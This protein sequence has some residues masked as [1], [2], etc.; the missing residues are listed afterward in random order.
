MP[1]PAFSNDTNAS[2]MRSMWVLMFGAFAMANAKFSIFPLM[3][4][5]AADLNSSPNEIL[6]AVFAYFWGGLIAAPIMAIVFRHWSKPR[7]LSLLS[8]WCFLGNFLTS[9]AT[10]AESLYWL[11]WFSGIPHAAFLAFATLL[12]TEVAPANKRGQYLGLSLIGISL[13]TIFMIPFNTWIGEDYGWQISFRFVALLDLL[14]FLLMHD[15]LPQHDTA[16][17]PQSLQAQLRVLKN[18]RLWLLFTV[19]LCILISTTA[20]WTYSISWFNQHPHPTLNLKVITLITL[21]LGFI[22]GQVAG[23]WAADHQVDRYIG[24]NTLYTLFAA[25]FVLSCLFDYRLGLIGLFLISIA[26]SLINVMMQIRL[27]TFP[28]A[29]LYMVLCLFNACIQLGNFIGSSLAKSIHLFSQEPTFTL[30]MILAGLASLAAMVWF[31]LIKHPK[32]LLPQESL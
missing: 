19:G 2:P 4:T 18:P 8:I 6:H 1:T 25:V 3:P 29:A 32:S 26:F 21:G 16:S 12:I 31:W 14:I 15:L 30:I 23:G 9:F 27:L 10:S 17:A 22:V 28:P 11:R 24:I 5:I 20:A 13:S 7:I